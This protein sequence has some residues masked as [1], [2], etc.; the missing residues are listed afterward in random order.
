MDHR[1]SVLMGVY[2]AED[3]IRNVVESIENQT[4]PDIEFVICDDASKDH[5]YQILQEL[6]QEYPNIVLL[7][8]RMNEGL[9]AALNRCLMNSHGSLI[10][11]M[12]S[13]DTCKPERFAVQRKFLEEHPEY[14]LV[15]SNMLLVDEHGKITYSKTNRAPTQDELPLDVPFLHPSVLMHRYVLEELGGYRVEKYT[16]R[17]EDLELWYRFFKAGYKG[18][19][20]PDYL[21][22]KAQGIDDYRKRKIRHGWEMFY[23]HL[24]GLRLLHAPAYKYLLAIK[25]VISASIPKRIMKAYHGIKFKNKGE[26]D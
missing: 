14:D 10:A 3:N 5:T 8:N 11:R 12:D 21:Y 25:P 22:I 16:R 20:L 6:A 2:N 7:H 13:D 17:C 4:D 15:G 18:Y 24:R 1:I 9:A 19:N 23:V 26:Q